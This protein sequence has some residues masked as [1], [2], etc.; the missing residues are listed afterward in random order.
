[1][2]SGLES[3]TENASSSS[4]RGTQNLTIS[5]VEP[6]VEEYKKTEPG[7]QDSDDTDDDPILTPSVRQR[8]SLGQ[9]YWNS[10]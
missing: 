2:L 9:R 1:M 7:D 8:E 5:E 10:Y 6:I 4:Q 3:G